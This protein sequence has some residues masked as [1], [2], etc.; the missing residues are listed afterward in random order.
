MQRNIQLV[1][2]TKI[3]L[4]LEEKT[5]QSK[6]ILLGIIYCQTIQR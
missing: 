3:L 5:I 4:F 1:Q 2:L 6:R